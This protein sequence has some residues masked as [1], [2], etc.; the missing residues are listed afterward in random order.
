MISS[1]AAETLRWVLE[2]QSGKP[3]DRAVRC[4][5]RRVFDDWLRRNPWFSS[6]PFFV[7]FVTSAVWFF[8]AIFCI[9]EN[10][11]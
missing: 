8:D 1:Q 3:G 4:L 2:R 6:S 10:K 7:L 5:W 9:M 11:A